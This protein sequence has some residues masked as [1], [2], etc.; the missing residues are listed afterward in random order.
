METWGDKPKSQVDNSTVDE[1]IALLI[2]AHDDDVDAHLDADQ[3]LQSHKAS[4][5]IDHLASS[6]VADKIKDFEV[7]TEKLTTNK[8][9]IWP[10]FESLDAWVDNGQGEFILFMGGFAVYTDPTTSAVFAV[11]TLCEDIGVKFYGKQPTFEVTFNVYYTSEQLIYVGVGDIENNFLGF[12]IVD[13][14][15]SFCVIISGVEYLETVVGV[16]FTVNHAYR[17]NV[18]DNSQIEFYIDEI[19]IYTDV[20]HTLVDDI[21]LLLFVISLTATSDREVNVNIFDIRYFQDR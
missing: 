12:K 17:V 6:I 1:E 13:D 16:D 9:H 3:S 20:A 2:Q 10:S 14:V 7:Y 19:L 15:M 4:D 18:V 5:I 8:I 11:Y 21:C